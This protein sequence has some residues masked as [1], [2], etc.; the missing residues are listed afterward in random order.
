MVGRWLSMRWTANEPSHEP[1]VFLSL[2]RAHDASEWLNS[3]REYVAP[4]QNGLVADRGGNIAIRASGSY[5]VRPGDGR[6]DV[7][8][9]GSLS[10]SDWTG[11]LPVSKYPFAMNPPQGFL[12]SANQQPVDPKV[13]R[14]LHGSD[15]YSPWRRLAHQQVAS[16]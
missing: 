1:D 13:N 16:C 4:T 15:W 7:I 3:M 12:A 6:G 9:D 8:R 11:I 14:S 10:S 5:P 2:A